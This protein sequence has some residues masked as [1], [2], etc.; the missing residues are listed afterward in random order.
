MLQ[1]E[2]LRFDLQVSA[3]TGDG[4]PALVIALKARL[5]GTESD[6]RLLVLERHRDALARTL[7]ALGECETATH[8]GWDEFVAAALRRG[9][10]SLGEITGETATEEL[11]DLIFSKFCLGK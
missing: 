5:N 7:E 11:L 4:L 2:G 3:H 6:D 10:H 1:S 8:E 9:L